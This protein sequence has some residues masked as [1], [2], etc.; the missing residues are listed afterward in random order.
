MAIVTS[1]TVVLVTINPLMMT[2]RRS[3][4]VTGQTRKDRIVVCVGMT[5]TAMIPLTFMLAAVNRKIEII[6][7]PGG[8]LPGI[9]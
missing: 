9:L 6:M 2:V 1:I 4:M 3:L 5:V 7:I 8:R